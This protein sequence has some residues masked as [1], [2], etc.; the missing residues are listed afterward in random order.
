MRKSVKDFLDLMENIEATHNEKDGWALL[1][2]LIRKQIA[3]EQNMHGDH[4]VKCQYC[5][6]EHDSRIA[7]PEYAQ[8]GA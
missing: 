7:C 8:R 3:V 1:K 2:E 4:V 6:K 5:K